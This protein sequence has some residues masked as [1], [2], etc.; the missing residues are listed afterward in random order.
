MINFFWF[1]EIVERILKNLSSSK[2]YDKSKYIIVCLVWIFG[3]IYFG[4]G[5]G[6]RGE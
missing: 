4:G 1:H 2:K 3:A 6:R 5:Y